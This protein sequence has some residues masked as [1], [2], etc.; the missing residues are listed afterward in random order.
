MRR[1]A[2]ALGSL[3]LLAGCSQGGGNNVAANDANAAA[4][5][6]EDLNMAIS[7]DELSPIPEAEDDMIANGSGVG[8]AVGNQ[9]APQPPAGPAVPPSPA[10]PQDR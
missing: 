2:L 4:A 9:A 1:L 6:G 3:A 5:E 8:N 7:G 10:P